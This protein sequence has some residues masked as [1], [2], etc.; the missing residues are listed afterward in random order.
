MFTLKHFHCGRFYSSL[1]SSLSLTIHEAA[2]IET[3]LKR[4]SDDWAAEEFAQRFY[5]NR[6]QTISAAGNPDSSLYQRRIHT[7]SKGR[8]EH[9][10]RMEKGIFDNGRTGK[11][12]YIYIHVLTSFI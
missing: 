11:M 8:E 6:R 5:N 10:A 1:L 3:R 4:Y 9:E 2:E 7:T 12:K